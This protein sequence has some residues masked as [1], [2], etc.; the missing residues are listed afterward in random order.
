MYSQN[1]LDKKYP[2]II[3]CYW[4]NKHNT[5][6]IPSYISLCKDTLIKSNQKD[7]LIISLDENSIRQYILDKDLLPITYDNIDEIFPTI[8]Q[9]V[10]Y[11]RLI[12]LEKYG[13]IWCDLD[14]IFFKSL[15]IFAN[16]LKKYDYVGFGCYY[17]DCEIRHDG[18]GYPANWMMIS[19]KNGI[20]VRNCLH[21]VK[22]KLKLANNTSIL[23]SNYHYFG[24]ELLKS[25]LTKLKN[26]NYIYYHVKS[27]CI[28][29]DHIG[30][31][32]TNSRML[33]NEE[34][35]ESCELYFIP[36]YNTSPGFP[37]SFYKLN[38]SEILNKDYLISKLFR[39]AFQF[40]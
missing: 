15:K 33:S 5:K 40:Y 35:D 36:I 16:Y 2:Y 8:P 18:Y 14:I 22:K 34:I 31:K 19:R 37:D 21:E 24:K 23:L 30:R 27:S 28:E 20:L 1:I 10:D 11:Y 6:D 4:E 26:E 7:F 38:R 32:W 9:K 29:R 17:S 12:L 3:F 39:K 13:G 25:V